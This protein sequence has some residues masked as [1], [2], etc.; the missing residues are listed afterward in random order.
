M[1]RK[2]P[3]TT[4]TTTLSEIARQ[5][6]LEFCRRIYDEAESAKKKSEINKIKTTCFTK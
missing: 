3:S 2:T 1:F 6:T 4:T 5:S